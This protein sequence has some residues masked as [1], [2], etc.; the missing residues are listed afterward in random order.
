MNEYSFMSHARLSNQGHEEASVQERQS[1]RRGDSEQLQAERRTQILDAATQ[2][3]AE[4]G[5]HRATIPDIA[6][7]AEI[8]VGTIYIY[9][10]SKADLLLGI[11]DRLNESEARAE[12]LSAGQTQDFEGFF[13]AYLRHRLVVLASSREMLR[14]VL[15]EVLA[16]SELRQRYFNSVI[17]PTLE[18][19]EQFT[20]AVIEHGMIRP[21][22]VPLIV[23]AMSG[24]VLGLLLQE[25]LGD[26]RMAAL[27]SAAPEELAALLYRG[28]RPEEDASQATTE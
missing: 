2:V 27:W 23:R 16:N 6:R 4:K 5:F 10:P 7:R 12:D 9:F 25:M 13:A 17:G 26:Q 15:P 21:V 22:N 28:L 11:L 20:A 24:M 14:A 8:A 18:L 19:A 3:F 1:R